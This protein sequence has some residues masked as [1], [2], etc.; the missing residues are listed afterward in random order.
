MM[1]PYPS[2][3]L[4]ATGLILRPFEARDFG[5]ALEL[6]RDPAVARFVPPLPGTDGAGVV[7]FYD[8]CRAAGTL[9]HLV[10]ADPATG[11]YLGET[12]LAP[13][14]HGVAET[15]CCVAPAARGRGLATAALV[16]ITDWALAE[17]GL[18]RVQ[19]FVAVENTPALRL[20]ESAGFEREGVLRSY[21]ELDGKRVDAVILARI[22]DHVV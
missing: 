12:M 3:P 4:V 21:W 13:G 7:A 16:L 2:P 17:L 9:L 14:E 5:P 1:L 15:G 8:E 6:Q 22:P 10:I 11:A 20:A 19:V 18:A